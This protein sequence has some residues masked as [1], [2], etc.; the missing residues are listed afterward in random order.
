MMHRRTFTHRSALA[1]L[2]LGAVAV[3]GA[4]AATGSAAPA[5][6]VVSAHLP[7]SQPVEPALTSTAAP[8]PQAPVSQRPTAATSPTRTSPPRSSRAPNPCAKNQSEH[9]VRVSLKQQHMW[10]CAKQTV[11]YG[12]PI[13]SGVVGEYTSTPTGQ[14]HIQGVSRN[15]VLT[16]NTGATF[17]VQYWIP[18]DA[19][20]FG[21]HD[22]SWQDFPYGSR[23]YRTEGSHGCVHMPLK[24]IAYLARWAPT[25]TPV[26]IAA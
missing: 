22:S 24:A 16:L 13:T 2:A 12:T 17:A 8:T 7:A 3:L 5:R 20:L 21:F 15:T 9:A 11:A 19:P 10:L 25:G 14:F 6:S 1:G 4:C 18:F 23:K 26:T